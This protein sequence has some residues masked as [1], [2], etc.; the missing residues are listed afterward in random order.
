M[1]L[2]SIT[3]APPCRTMAHLCGAGAALTVRG[4]EVT[5]PMIAMVAAAARAR[6]LHMFIPLAMSVLRRA[7]Y[8]LG[9]RTRMVW[10]WYTD[11]RIA[12]RFAGILSAGPMRRWRNWQTHKLE[13]L[14]PQG[15]GVQVPSSAP[16][17]H[18]FF[19]R[20]HSTDGHRSC[21]PSCFGC[22]VY[23]RRR[24]AAAGQVGRPGRGVRRAGLTDGIRAAR[25]GEPSD[26]ADDVVGDYLYADVDWADDSDVARVFGGRVGALG[27]YADPAE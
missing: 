13:V 14:A 9:E 7:V 18:I 15:I 4:A 6:V 17:Q 20:F 26:A 12:H 27:A 8:R 5:V 11:P 24:A 22:A 2:R 1:D 19:G 3:P 23:D 25:C 16:I 21:H 10:G